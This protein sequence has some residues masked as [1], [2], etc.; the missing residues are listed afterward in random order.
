MLQNSVLEFWRMFALCCAT[1]K[2]IFLVH[3]QMVN[4][5][6]RLHRVEWFWMMSQ[7]QMDMVYFKVLFQN[8]LGG[9]E[10]HHK[11]SPAWKL[12]LESEYK[13]IMLAV[14]LWYLWNIQRQTCTSLFVLYKVFFNSLDFDLL[15]ASSL[16]KY[17]R[18][19]DTQFS[20]GSTHQSP[21]K[22]IWK[23]FSNKVS[24]LD[25]IQRWGIHRNW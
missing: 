11:E 9:I 16:Q 18:P 4:Q 21:V 1:F 19:V 24:A 12:Y 10:E 23:F 22:H 15:S 2:H 14:T 7:K 20:A 3:L 5:L 6:R 25:E 13:I 8:L 17:S